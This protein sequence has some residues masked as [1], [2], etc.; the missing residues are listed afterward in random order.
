MMGIP[1][2]ITS[3]SARAVF[4]APIKDGTL[5]PYTRPLADR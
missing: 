4:P 5:P 1:P 2:S 3:N